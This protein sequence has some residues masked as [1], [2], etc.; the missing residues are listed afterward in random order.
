M[1][2]PF[3]GL[4]DEESDS[5][6][7]SLRS[8]GWRQGCVLEVELPYDAVIVADDGKPRADRSVHGR[9]MIASQDCDLAFVQ[10]TSTVPSVELRPVF[11]HDP[12]QEWGI[13]GV[14]MRLNGRDYL[15]AHSPRLIVA[16]A[17]LNTAGHGASNH[18][19]CP[20]QESA[21][22]I[23]TWL[24]RRYDRPAVPGRFV[25]CHNE[26]SQ[27]VRAKKYRELTQLVRDVLVVYEEPVPGRTHYQLAAVLPSKAYRDPPVDLVE[28]LNDWLGDIALSVPDDLGVATGLFV[29]TADEIS[30]AFLEASYSL[31]ASEATWPRSGKAPQGEP[32]LGAG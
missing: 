20:T 3:S 8:M 10:A 30:V 6:P 21:R 27:R 2:S 7:G 9:W 14:R 18:A 23:K 25:D 11:D 16:P 22:Y 26:L 1:T 4:L 17:V 13:R 28:E 29:R 31:D 5:A 32:P 24:G 12:P 19:T 15:H